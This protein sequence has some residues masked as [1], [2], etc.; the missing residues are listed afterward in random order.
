MN[1]YILEKNGF[2]IIYKSRNDFFVIDKKS[3]A[4]F[5]KFIKILCTSGTELIRQR[6]E[7]FDRTKSLNPVPEAWQ[8]EYSL[9]GNGYREGYPDGYKL[10]EME[11]DFSLARVIIT[12]LNVT[13]TT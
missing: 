1:R 8:T 2:R 7:F 10:S 13:N 4:G 6:K 5:F 9:L 12:D 3:K 11:S